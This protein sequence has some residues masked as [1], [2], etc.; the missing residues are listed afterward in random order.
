MPF[1]DAVARQ[2][3]K[4]HSVDNKL[5]NVIRIEKLYCDSVANK[6]K[7]NNSKKNL[8]QCLVQFFKDGPVL[9]SRC[10]VHYAV[11]CKM[12]PTFEL[13][14]KEVTDSAHDGDA[15]NKLDNI[16]NL[17]I[18]YLLT[19]CKL[20]YKKWKI[21]KGTLYNDIEKCF[22]YSLLL[23]TIFKTDRTMKLRKT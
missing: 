17:N 11:S 12:K 23:K 4:A 18:E 6:V 10:D 2:E 7:P 8:S 19:L 16:R 20:G 3:C 9:T 21:K 5:I 22:K 14:S 13:C 1:N 15:R